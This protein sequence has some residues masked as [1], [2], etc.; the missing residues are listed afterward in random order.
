LHGGHAEADAIMFEERRPARELRPFVHIYGV[1]PAMIS[2]IGRSCFL[3]VI[4]VMLLIH[5]SMIASKGY[6]GTIED[7]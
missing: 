5:V 1:Q 7:A 4:V 3:F 2:D 6:K